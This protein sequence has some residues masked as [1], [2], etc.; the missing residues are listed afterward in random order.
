MRTPVVGTTEKARGS[1]PAVEGYPLV[2]ILPR[3]RREPFGTLLSATREVGDVARLGFPGQDWVLLSH[4]EH[5]EHVLKENRANYVKGYDGARALL[6]NGLPLN[7]GES[8]L[9]QRR[10]MQPAFHRRRLERFAATMVGKAEETLKGWE[11]AASVGRPVDVGLEMTLLT[12][13][14]IV[15]TMFGSSVGDERGERIARAFDAGM[16][17][18]EFRSQLP[19]WAS[20]LPLPVNRRFARAFAV[21]DEE[22]YRIIGERRRERRAGGDG[23]VRDDLLG[24]LLEARDEETGEGMDEGQVRDEVINVYLA[25]HEST[26]VLLT[27]V[28]YLLSK[29]PGAARKVREEALEVIGDRMPGLEDL[30]KLVYARMVV[31]E[32]LRLYPSAWVLA[33]KAVGDDEIGGY[34]IPAGTGLFV[35]PYVTHRRPDLWENP[36]GFDPERFAPDGNGDEGRPRFSYYPFGGGPRLCI[37]QN[38]ALMEAT[39]IVATIARSYRLDLVPGEAVKPLPRGTLRPSSALRMVPRRAAGESPKR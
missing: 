13:R 1:I 17:G 32:T 22:V 20:R 4:P 28:W 38:F 8:W 9:R 36:E 33:R 12:Q 24:L 16:R 31:D 23:E 35:C 19:L 21:L 10:L 26:A 15:K 7:E 39:L 29:H 18:I 6:G 25:G 2:G 5:V 34:R 3:F 37:G 27:W 30:P 11:G 14:V